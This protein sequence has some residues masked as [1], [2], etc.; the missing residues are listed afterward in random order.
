MGWIKKP[1]LSLVLMLI[2][3][4]LTGSQ[5]PKL[6]VRAYFKTQVSKESRYV[7]AE[8]ELFKSFS[9]KDIAI[10]AVPCE[11]RT[12]VSAIV[13]EIRK[14][15]EISMVI[16]PL[17]FPL[18]IGRN[19]A[20]AR[21]LKLIGQF[22]NREYA[23]LLVFISKNPES[24]ARKIHQVVRKK[25]GFIFGISYIGAMAM[26]YV[27]M[28]L[29]YL[30]PI[31][32]L[33]MFAVFFFTLKNFWAAVL[34]FL[35]SSLTTVYLLGT[36]A[37][38]GKPVTMENV[39]M[40]FIT[41]IMGSSAA[42]HYFSRYLAI[43][44]PN[45]FERSYR[46][47]R[48]TFVALLMTVLTTIVGF[49]SLGLTSSPVMREL[50][51]SGAIGVGTSGLVT[52]VFLPPIATLIDPKRNFETKFSDQSVR[53][54]WNLVW[55][56]TMIFFF[57]LFIFNVESEFHSL[58]FFRPS[59]KVMK[60]ARVVE[61]IAGI[62]VPIFMKID[63][64]VDVLSSEGLETL[65]M[66]R[67][68]LKDYCVRTFSILD[69]FE[70]FPQTLRSFIPMLI[71]EGMLY[72]RKNSSLLMIVFPKRVDRKTYSQIEKV[73][74]S[75]VSG[76]VKSIQLS[77]ED[78]KYMEM[79]EFVVENLKVSLIFALLVIVLMMGSM[80]KNFKLGLIS[81]VPIAATLISL[82]GAMG[83]FRV[84]INAVS[85]CLL[86]IV[87]GAGIDYAIHFSCAY[88]KHNS[89]NEAYRL[90]RRPI[91]ANAFGVALGF[92]V[93]FLSPMKVH[94]HIAALIC[95]GMALASTYTL[96]WMTSVFPEK[97]Q[98]ARK[99]SSLSSSTSFE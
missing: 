78:F 8:R 92:S 42:L 35:P 17:E 14:F 27:R 74:S 15:D 85:A 9:L 23:L 48:E 25:G 29:V 53:K 7:H 88:V 58:I 99:A 91:L 13:Q 66:V 41:L 32:L 6:R 31:A 83:L 55:F 67:E 26:D 84:P 94:V 33:V 22:E 16:N 60:G 40:P 72:D 47:M 19:S 24:T 43:K 10:V 57:C 5:L 38:V 59:S 65:R 93:L 81:C 52:F 51:F 1:W 39:L 20:L 97:V 44:D 75:H 62:K 87:L 56:F 77:G 30:T 45:R 90:T 21:Q 4:I 2:L 86:N 82:Y 11:D 69:L 76:S 73:A 64:N 89:A 70:I 54:R 98:T 50:G 3:G 61:T 80:L 68:S 63:L 34:A 37:F 96:I 79:N 71:P 28:I 49:L 46:A 18:T 95:V 12:G 36:Y